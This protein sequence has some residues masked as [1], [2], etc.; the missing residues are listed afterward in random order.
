MFQMCGGLKISFSLGYLF[1]FFAHLLG[2][3]FF[4]DLLVFLPY[5]FWMP[6]LSLY[7]HTHTYMHIC[8]YNIK[9]MCIHTHVCVYIFINDIFSR[10]ISCFEASFMASFAKKRFLKL[11][12][13][14]LIWISMG[15][16]FFMSCL[17]NI[18][19]FL[20]CKAPKHYLILSSDRL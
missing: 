8:M 17:K 18:F 5:I 15:C 14:K 4:I 1:I 20:S 7:I 9:H 19:L 13:V 6:A 10:F 2:C 3:N 12:V 16:V 11:D